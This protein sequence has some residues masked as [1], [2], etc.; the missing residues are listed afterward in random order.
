MFVI[1][2]FCVHFDITVFHPNP[3]NNSVQCVSFQNLSAQPLGSPCWTVL[4]VRLRGLGKVLEADCKLR[5]QCY[6]VVHL[7]KKENHTKHFVAT[8]CNR[9]QSS[10]SVSKASW[11]R[12]KAVLRDLEAAWERRR[13][14]LLLPK[15]CKTLSICLRNQLF[16]LSA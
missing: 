2:V 9:L 4:Q 3:S 7:L 14:V 12:H 10:L 5:T 8:F 16:K 1:T 6:R 13:S 15:L 11:K